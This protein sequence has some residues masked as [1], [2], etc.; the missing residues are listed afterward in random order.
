MVQNHTC[1]KK[2]SPHWHS[3]GINVKKSGNGKWD[4]RAATQVILKSL[5]WLEILENG[6][7]LKKMNFSAPKWACQACQIS[8]GGSFIC[9]LWE[10]GKKFHEPSMNHTLKLDF[11]RIKYLE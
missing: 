7:N 11:V 3:G 5:D 9:K 4:A 1:K 10:N 2:W 8:L 6:Y